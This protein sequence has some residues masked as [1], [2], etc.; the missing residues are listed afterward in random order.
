MDCKKQKCLVHLLRDLHESAQE[1]PAFAAGSFF[2]RSKRLVKEMLLLKSQWDELDDKP[3][4]LRAKRLEARLDELAHAHYDEANAV[5][6]AKRLRRHQKELT[7]FLWEKHLDGTNN[8]AERALRP[9]VVARKISGGSRSKAGADAWAT[10]ASL[11]RTARQ[12]GKNLL[13]SVKSMLVSAWA[14]KKPP[15]MPAGP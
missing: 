6:L 3:Y 13:E 9:A 8:A 7:P 10:V 2:R 1:C 12:Q 14:S 15:T 11:V 5:R 4:D